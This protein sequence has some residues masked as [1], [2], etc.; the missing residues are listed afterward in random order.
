MAV[1]GTGQSYIRTFAPGAQIKT[2]TSQYLLVG[3]VPATTSSDFTVELCG[4]TNTVGT[5]TATSRFCIGANQSYLS[6][7]S[8][9]CAVTMFGEAKIKCADSITAGEI[10]VAYEGVS[11]TTMAGRISA[12]D[13]GVSVTVATQS[14]SSYRYIVGRALESGSTGTVIDVFINPTPMNAFAM[15]DA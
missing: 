15:A 3:M 2:S 5:P 6:S 1:M 13:A 10:V 8:K 12:L 4:Q 7:G 9:E 11:T 14:V